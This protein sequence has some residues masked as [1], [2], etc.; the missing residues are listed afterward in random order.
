MKIKITAINYR[1]FADNLLN[2]KDSSEIVESSQEDIKRH[3][4]LLLFDK[5]YSYLL[6]TIDKKLFICEPL[7]KETR[8]YSRR[9]ITYHPLN[10]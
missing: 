8:Q 7:N 6:I 3:I 2:R 4:D 5:M 9:E 1:S 10:K